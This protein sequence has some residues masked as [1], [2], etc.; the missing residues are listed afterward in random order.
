MQKLLLLSIMFM[1]LIIPIRAARFE[2]RQ[3]GFKFTLKW[4]TAYCAFYLFGLLY[5]YPRLH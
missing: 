1:A 4:M 5:L 2:R 3:D